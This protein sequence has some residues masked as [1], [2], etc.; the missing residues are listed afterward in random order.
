MEIHPQ[1]QRV[2][3]ILAAG[4]TPMNEMTGPEGRA[5]YDKVLLENNPITIEVAATDDFDIPGPHG[6]IGVRSYVPLG[7]DRSQPN[8]ALVFY[9]GG[10]WVIGSVASRDQTCRALATEGH[11]I[12]YSIDYRLAPEHKFPAA[13]DDAYA[14]AC[15]AVDSAARLGID[16][17]RIALGG[18]SAGGNLT[19]VVTHLARDNGGPTFA[20]QLLIYPA[21]DIFLTLGLPSYELLHEGHFITAELMQWYRDHYLLPDVDRTD[22]RHS[23][24]LAQDF[25]NLP[26]AYIQTAEIDPI[27]DDGKHYGELLAAAGVP[28]EYKCYPGQ[29]HGFFNWWAHIDACAEAHRDAGAALQRALA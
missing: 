8:P 20:F 5:Y 14:A 19:A 4:G 29:I 3:E 21:T 22:I 17:D 2:L 1:S 7:L 27:R 10:G 13:I 23:P 6:P 11:C 26:P 12:V 15:W 18:D 16:P 9:H 28:V 24:S 25:R